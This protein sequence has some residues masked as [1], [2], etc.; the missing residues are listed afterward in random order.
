LVTENQNLAHENKQLN[1]LLK[2]YENTL[3]TVMGKFRSFSVSTKKFKERGRS[4]R[5]G[6]KWKRG[7]GGRK[8]GAG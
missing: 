6:F 4:L 7:E 8:G 5:W 2:E 1:A 3:E